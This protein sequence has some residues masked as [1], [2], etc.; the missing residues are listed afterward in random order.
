MNSKKDSNNNKEK[1]VKKPF[2][3]PKKDFSFLMESK[4]IQTILER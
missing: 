4:Y 2:I 1:E 3:K